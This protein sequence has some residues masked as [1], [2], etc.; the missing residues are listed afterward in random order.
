MLYTLA[1]VAKATDLRELT[2]L[3][4]IE[5][6]QIA[7]TKDMFGKWHVEGTELHRLYPL[8]AERDASADAA[9]GDAVPRSTTLEAEIEG[10]IRNAG[11]SLREQP[12]ASHPHTG[13]DQR[14]ASQ[15]PLAEPACTAATSGPNEGR[16]DKS[17]GIDQAG[18]TVPATASAWDHNPRIDERDKILVSTSHPRTRR[19]RIARKTG[20]LIMV[21]GIG[22]IGGFSSNHFLRHSPVSTPIE[23]KLKSSSQIPGSENQTKSVIPAATRRDV[24]PGVPNTGKIA[25]AAGNGIAGRDELTQSIEQV[26]TAPTTKA[27]AAA[28]QNTTKSD[29]ASAAIARQAKILPKPMPVPETK[30]TT[31]KG[32]RV[33]D[34]VDGTAILEGP[35][36]ISKAA[37]GD[38]VPGL[39][40]VELYCFMG[41]SLDRLDQQGS[42][43]D[44]IRGRGFN[45]HMKEVDGPAV[46]QHACKLRPLTETMRT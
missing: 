30:P 36:G 28:Q 6:G 24:P 9:Q 35:N 2:I 21:L 25:S 40:R 34:V 11:D 32:W 43:F 1:E 41:Q 38:M 44:P 7:G 45:D 14:Q 42:H 31:I 19:A 17:P 22:W 26:L 23:Q 12:H 46:F 10:F 29:T 39:G 5:G 20:A 16:R 4:A 18:M 33:R 27:S 13:G 15:N 37:R 8:M 3:R